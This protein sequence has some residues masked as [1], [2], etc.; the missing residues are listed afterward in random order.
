MTLF[1]LEN[2][3]RTSSLL[4]LEVCICFLFFLIVDFHTLGLEDGNYLRPMT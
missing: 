2:P 3:A 4:K 1:L